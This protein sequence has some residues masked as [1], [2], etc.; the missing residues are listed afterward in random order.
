MY[1][2]CLLFLCLLAFTPTVGAQDTSRPDLERIRKALL[3]ART[4]K[5]PARGR[6]L[7]PSPA[8]EQRSLDWL[9]KPSAVG[10]LGPIPTL[11]DAPAIGDWGVGLKGFNGNFNFLDKEALDRNIESLRQATEALNRINLQFGRS[12]LSPVPRPADGTLLPQNSASP[13][14]RSPVRAKASGLKIPKIIRETFNIFPSCVAGCFLDY[15][16]CQKR[17]KAGRYRNPEACENG[18]GACKRT[19]PKK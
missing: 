13:A 8:P 14:T 4:P 6:N 7:T 19:C 12:A 17:A 3:D 2:A 15:A 1:K 16:A 5:P 10:P 18:L 9:F 11:S